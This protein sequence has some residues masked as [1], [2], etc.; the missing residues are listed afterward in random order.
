MSDLTENELIDRHRQSLIDAHSACQVLGRNADTDILM[1]RGKHYLKLKQS[2]E[3][4]EGSARQMAHFRED[5]RWLKL[6]I[7]YAKATRVAQKHYVQL[8][9]KAFTMMMTI[10]EQGHRH[11]N[12][13]NAKTGKMGAI[14]PARPSDF[15]LMPDFR[16]PGRQRQIQ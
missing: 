15:L 9:W 6:G 12:D 14:L 5:A 1:P 13:L 4:L 8:N 10:F 2:L 7:L 11:L 16:V 3:L